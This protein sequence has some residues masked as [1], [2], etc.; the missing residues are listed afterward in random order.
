M[1][2]YGDYTEQYEMAEEMRQQQNNAEME[3]S[4]KLP[5]K[6]HLDRLDVKQSK[7]RL[8]AYEK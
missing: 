8:K 1:G 7:F 4:S 6:N 5:I 2:D 3:I